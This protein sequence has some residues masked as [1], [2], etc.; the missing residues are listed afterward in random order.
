MSYILNYIHCIEAKGLSFSTA[1][2]SS[3]GSQ[4]KIYNLVFNSDHVS[5]MCSV[6]VFWVWPE[7]TTSD[8]SPFSFLNPQVNLTYPTRPANC[9]KHLQSLLLPTLGLLPG[10]STH[11]CY[12]TL[13]QLFS[14][15]LSPTS[16]RIWHHSTFW[17]RKC[18]DL[19]LEI[20]GWTVG[21]RK[22]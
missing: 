17:S 15:F 12:I 19:I 6:P 8:P 7:K 18:V 22:K 16:C 14:K 4:T 1:R 13:K 2:P 21:E 20:K 11:T 9:F 5:S 3:G 10:W